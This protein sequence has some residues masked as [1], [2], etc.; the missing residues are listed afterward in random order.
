MTTAICSKEQCTGCGACFN[1]CPKECI[2]M[3]SDTE[4]FLY[5]A[6][7]PECCD[8]CD[9]CKNV[10]PIL[11]S[12]EPNH[13]STP[14]VYACWNKDKTI[15]FQ[16]ASGGAFSAFAGSVLDNGGIVFGAAFDESMR[17]KHIAVNQREELGKLRSSKYVQS[18]I[19]CVYVEIRKLLGQNRSVLFSGTPCQVAA[20][21]EFLGKNNE[22]LLTCDLA[23]MGVPSPGLFAK[24]VASLE[25]H[26]QAKL[27]NINF[28]HKYKSWELFSTMAVFNDGRKR[29]L[30]GYH[31]SFMFGFLSH[32]SMRNACYRC[33]YAKLNRY[34]DITLGD[35][36]G[37]GDFVPFYHNTRN[38]ISLILVNS[39]KGH[40]LL[41][42]ISSHLYLE[43]RTLEE[44]KHK[45]VLDHP[46]S[47]P[48]NRKQFFADYQ[49]LEYEDLVKIYL[50]DKGVKGIIKRVVPRTW[51]FYLR[52]YI[53]RIRR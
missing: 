16:S 51:L 41:G 20:L 1:I 9:A 3:I 19:G 33:P 53:R 40:R 12:P 49:R 21:N 30:T 14:K 7:D 23:C 2:R 10:C 39:E 38:G 37:I 43:E 11:H 6:I 42:G 13:S 47:E 22:N 24:Y 50:V 48:K 17:L 4:G 45:P 28:R 26:F 18:D 44:A 8:D 15:C 31:D 32:S 27:I 25:K 46:W 36:W 34:G 52:K 5:P 35:F 29:I